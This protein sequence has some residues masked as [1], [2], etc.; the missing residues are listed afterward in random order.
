MKKV[1]KLGLVIFKLK[2]YHINP[3]KFN[4]IIVG[5]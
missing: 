4:D 3:I 1:N 5:Q 2:I